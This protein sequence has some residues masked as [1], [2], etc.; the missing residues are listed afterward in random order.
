MSLATRIAQGFQAVGQGVKA[1]TTRVGTLES[2]GTPRTFA[3]PEALSTTTPRCPGE[4]VVVNAENGLSFSWVAVAVGINWL[5]VTRI[6]CITSYRT[7]LTT[8]T[9]GSTRLLDADGVWGIYNLET[10]IPQ[11][12][13]AN[14]SWQ[15]W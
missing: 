15:T 6:S 11:T 14:N 9:N 3:T 10:G 1:L 2:N 5:P 8:L 12:R 7:R 4:A 13:V